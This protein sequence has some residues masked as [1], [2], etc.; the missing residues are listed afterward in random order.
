MLDVQFSNKTSANVAGAKMNCLFSH[1]VDVGFQWIEE[2][3]EGGECGVIRDRGE[4]EQMEQMLE[5]RLMVDESKVKN[6]AG[7]REDE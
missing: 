7:R 5:K 1:H 4:M 6:C 3:G 2:L